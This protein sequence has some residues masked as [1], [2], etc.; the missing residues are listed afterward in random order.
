[1]PYSLFVIYDKLYLLRFKRVLWSKYILLN[2][3]KK[4]FAGFTSGIEFR[5]C[6]G[7]GI[8]DCCSSHSERVFCSHLVCI[9]FHVFFCVVFLYC[10]TGLFGKFAR[11]EGMEYGKDLYYK[12]IYCFFHA[13]VMCVLHGL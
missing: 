2:W 11:P 13:A 9:N 6:N 8:Y 1:M 10:L 7:K 4:T 5:I 3:L 12:V